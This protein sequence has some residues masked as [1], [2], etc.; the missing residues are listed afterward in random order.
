MVDLQAEFNRI[1]SSFESDKKRITFDQYQMLRKVDVDTL[2]DSVSCI[3]DRSILNQIFLMGK[4]VSNITLDIRTI[5]LAVTNAMRPMTTILCEMMVE[6]N[7]LYSKSALGSDTM[8][9]RGKTF[10]NNLLESLGYS[11]KKRKIGY[12]CMVTKISGDGECVVA[13]HIAPARSRVKYLRN[14]GLTEED[15]NSS[16]NGLLLSKNIE[17]AF[18]RL[19]LSFIRGPVADLTG[20]PRDGFTMK[21]WDDDC[22]DT[23]IWNGSKK[24]IGEYDGKQLLLGSHNPLK[25]VLSYQAYTAFLHFRHVLNVTVS[26][27]SEFGSD[28]ASNYYKNRKLMKDNLLR[29][30]IEEVDHNEGFDNDNTSL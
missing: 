27:P 18:D 28:N 4:S 7:N 15:V 22:R 9:D 13:A 12:P 19:Q 1:R 21:I 5:E 8:S 3:I 17:I 14:I 26:E 23:F 6:Q 24:R 29:D 20:L 10:R 30:V 16:R 25:R 11:K 2:I